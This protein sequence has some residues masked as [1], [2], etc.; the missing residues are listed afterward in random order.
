VGSC[1]GSIRYLDPVFGA[2]GSV[3]DG[4]LASDGKIDDPILLLG[5]T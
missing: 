4:L 3:R 5:K 1:F 2:A